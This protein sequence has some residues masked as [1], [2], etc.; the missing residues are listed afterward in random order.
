MPTPVLPQMPSHLHYPSTGN[1]CPL[2]KMLCFCSKGDHLLNPLPVTSTT[3][4]FLT[5]HITNSAFCI[6]ICMTV[7]QIPPT[8]EAHSTST[9]PL[10]L[11]CVDSSCSKFIQICCTYKGEHEELPVISRNTSSNATLWMRAN[12]K[13][14]QTPGAEQRQLLS[15]RFIH[16]AALYLYVAC[17]CTAYFAR[18]DFL[19][20]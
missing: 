3:P 6:S 12:T 13:S 19:P 14:L 17:E 5:P 18:P 10:V 8:K 15:F 11:N 2:H 20:P 7:Q 16:K 4:H 9:N 1:P